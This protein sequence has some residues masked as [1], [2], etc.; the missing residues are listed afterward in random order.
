M[1]QLVIKG[2]IAQHQINIVLSML[3]SWNIDAE[4]VM[5]ADA[6]E[7]RHK[8]AHRANGILHK[9]ANPS[10]QEKEKEA[11]ANHVKEKYENI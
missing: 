5:P 6:T 3:N 11:W 8:A 7:L 10:L 9:Y 2:N 1:T 4:I